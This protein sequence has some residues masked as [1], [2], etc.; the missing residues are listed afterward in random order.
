MIWFFLTKYFYDSYKK[1]PVVF[2]LLFV[3]SVIARDR[4][5]HLFVPANGTLMLWD[6]VFYAFSYPLIVTFF[7]PLFYCY[8]ISDIFKM[9][10]TDASIAVT[11]LRS[12]S[13]FRYYSSKAV[14]IIIAA[15]I[16][17]VGFFCILMLV[18]AIFR[19][20]VQG[21]H[22]FPLVR[23]SIEGGQNIASLLTIQ[24]G[25]SILHLTTIGF[26]AAVLSLIFNKVS[27]AYLGVLFLAGL[28]YNAVMYNMSLLPYSVFAFNVRSHHYPFL[29]G[30]VEN[31]DYVITNLTSYTTSYVILVLVVALLFLFLTGWHQFRK[32]TIAVEE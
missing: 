20:P 7:T 11:L 19:L 22:Y 9:D 4:A 32:K 13:R 1:W 8:L 2:G 28:G 12:G 23:L 26:F 24:H 27:Y 16:F 5:S 29:R 21:E 17:F 6:Y 25:L 15:N 10:F 30:M 18:A 3:L 14:V 31:G